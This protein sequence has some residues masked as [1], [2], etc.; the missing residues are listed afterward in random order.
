MKLRATEQFLADCAP[1]GKVKTIR[2]DNGTEFTSEDFSSPLRKN[3]IKHERSAPY[4]P[5]QNETAERQWRTIFEMGRCMLLDKKLP[6]ELWP[7]A[8]HTAVYTINRCLNSRVNKTPCE[9]WTGRRPNIS[10]MRV[11]GCEYYTYTQH[12]KAKLEE[13]GRKGV[14]VSY[15]R[16]SPANLVYFPDIRKVIKCRLVHFVSK[17]SD[18]NDKETQTGGIPVDKD[19]VTVK[20]PVVGKV[21]NINKE[22]RPEYV[23]ENKKREEI[24][25]IVQSTINTRILVERRNLLPISLTMK[26]ISVS[27]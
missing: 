19:D 27:I 25:P 1:Y 21:P 26:C 20:R 4:S 23:A 5:H 13:R 3:N 24:S 6:K 12:H 8:V 22:E 14:F 9:A 10:N 7:Y 2:S 16:S 11:F 18:V 17:D 15:N